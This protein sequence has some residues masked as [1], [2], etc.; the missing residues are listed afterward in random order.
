MTE[1]LEVVRSGP[2]WF[3]VGQ[4]GPAQSPKGSNRLS[5]INSK[6]FLYYIA[7]YVQGL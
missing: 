6:F 1:W 5:E 7:L 4:S 2:K 3:E